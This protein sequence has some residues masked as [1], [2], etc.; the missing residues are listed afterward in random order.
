MRAFVAAFVAQLDGQRLQAAL[1]AD[2]TA[3]GRRNVGQVP[4]RNY[5]VTLKFLGEIDPAPLAGAAHAVASLAGH[6]TTARVSGLVGFPRSSA[7]R[8][9][10]AELD[11]EEVLEA[12]WN[13]L[14]AELGAEDRPFRPH[15]TVVR[16]RRPR[17][18]RPMPLGEPLTLTLETPR[19]YR[20][21]QTRGGVAYRPVV[22]D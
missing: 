21:D 22:L 6:A 5:H 18:F 15:V 9:V 7:A 2:L 8:L 16:F 10:A 1:P 11:T 3:P 13:T 17:A 20:S 4:V 12:W 19:L 14:A